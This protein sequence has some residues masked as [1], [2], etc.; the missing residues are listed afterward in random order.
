[1]MEEFPTPRSV[2]EQLRCPAVAVIGPSEATGDQMR[3]A[4]RIGRA[5]AEGGAV[6]ITGGRGGIMEA[7]CEGAALAGGTTVGILPG[8]NPVES[9]PNPFVQ[10]PVFTGMGNGRNAI[11][12]GSAGAV[13]A[14]G[15]GYGTLSEIGLALKAGKP[16]ILLRSWTITPS[17]PIPG[18]DVL[19][20]TALNPGEAARLALA[21]GTDQSLDI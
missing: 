18:M 13:I 16:V 12:V 14:I 3:T 11:V 5:L 19:L 4:R 21:L 6:V 9:P 15:G 8:A 2:F 7:A 20:R 10:I 1:M 17:I